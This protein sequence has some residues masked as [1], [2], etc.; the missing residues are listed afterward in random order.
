MENY[1]YKNPEDI[2][3]EKDNFEILKCLVVNKSDYKDIQWTLICDRSGSMMGDRMECLVKT[4]IEMFKYFKNDAK[5]KSNHHYI[6]VIAFDDKV[7]SLHIEIND[8][9]DIESLKKNVLKIL[10]PRGMT[11]IGGFNA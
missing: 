3:S 5:D 2:K 11:N 1:R 4:L 6:H 7:S 8:L 10:Q 9:T